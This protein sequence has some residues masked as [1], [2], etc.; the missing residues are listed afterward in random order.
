M[1]PA[2]GVVSERGGYD[3]AVVGA[4]IVGLATAMKLLERR[5]RLRLAVLDK[6]PVVGAHQTAHNS[7]VL[8]RGI[9]YAPGSLRA[10]LCVAGAE[11]LVRFCD[12]R[13][14]AVQRCGK[15]IVAVD[16]SELPG[17]D[18]LHRRGVA[19]GVPG[20]E[21][22]GPQR[23][24]EIEPHVRG[25]A[26]LLSPQTGIVDFAQ[27]AA[28]YAEVVAEHGGEILLS[29]GVRAV[30]RSGAG[31]TLETDGGELQ[32]GHLLTCAGLHSDW[33][34]A[35][36]EPGADRA[37]RVVPF[38]GDYYV[39]CPEM[40]HLARNLVYPVPD[41]RFPF[42]GVHFTRRP[43]GEVWAGP[44]AVLAF[45][46]EGYRRTDLSLRDLGS[47]L[48]FRGFWRMASSHWRMGL[49]E[50]LRDYSKRAF[51]AALRRYVPELRSDDLLPGPSGVRA[52]ALRID[53]T[54]VDDFVVEVGASGRAIHVRNAPSPAA[55]SSLAIGSLIADRADEVF[56]L[57][58]R[59]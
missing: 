7:A 45:A 41:P 56:E 44:N 48:A 30:H 8:H 17:L 42:L 16:E 13:G 14:I 55:T 54:L 22:I 47:T 38:R 58:R 28:A 24:E 46:R 34:A 57:G 31:L 32:T 37:L 43:D 39:L 27:V 53:G 4:G 26:A 20:L 1:P 10:R 33:V 11:E 52:Q 50:M 25:I 51:V 21:R 5:P 9:Y 6:E 35:L 40:R 19:N 18:E 29:H 3:V 2:G 12:E 36:T 59:G 49:G 15:V 23:L